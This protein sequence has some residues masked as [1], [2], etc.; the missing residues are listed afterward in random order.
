[1]SNQGWSA[2]EENQGVFS[3]TQNDNPTSSGVVLQERSPSPAPSKQTQQQTA[4]RSTTPD[5]TV[6]AADVAIRDSNGNAISQSN[7]LPISGTI[8]V[9]LDSAKTPTVLNITADTITE[10]TISLPQT[11]KKFSIKT[12]NHSSFSMSYTLG[13]TGTNFIS[14][15]MGSSYNEEGLQL[16]A[17]LSV[18][19]KPNKTS[20][21]IEVLYWQ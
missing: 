20:E 21:I 13:G 15:G 17:P 14:V 12:R 10:Y 7:P 5:G 3:G 18:S 8:S 6:V 11:T 4:V 16:L 9:S 2:G 19:V 1:M